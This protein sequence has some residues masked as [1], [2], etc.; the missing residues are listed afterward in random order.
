MCDNA[1]ELRKSAKNASED[2]PELGSVQIRFSRRILKI[3]DRIFRGFLIRSRVKGGNTDLGKRITH[4]EWCTC[5]EINKKNYMRVI[6][7]V[8]LRA[9]RDHFCKSIDTWKRG[10]IVQENV[11]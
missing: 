9:F 11:E 10:I 3:F 4:L 5:V 8:L 6:W 1:N 7:V 2:D